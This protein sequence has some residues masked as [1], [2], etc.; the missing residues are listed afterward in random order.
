MLFR[1]R[2]SSS[3]SSRATPPPPPST[4]D[5]RTPSSS[6][7]LHPTRILWILQAFCLT[8]NYNPHI[9]RGAYDALEHKFGP[10]NGEGW[11]G[12]KVG[13]G[14]VGLMRACGVGEGVRVTERGS[15][16]GG[17]GER[18]GEGGKVE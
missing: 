13:E 4:P 2:R 5:A 10:G 17:G 14:T 3:L 9:L 1:S 12:W 16:F 8:T 6:P 7:S 15:G 11:E 18:R